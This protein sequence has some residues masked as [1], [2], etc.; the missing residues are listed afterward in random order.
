MSELYRI[1]D[2]NVANLKLDQAPYWQAK[3]LEESD[4]RA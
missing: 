2:P 4:E 1:I 3:S